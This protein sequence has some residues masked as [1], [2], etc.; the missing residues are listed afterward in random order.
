MQ[1]K[2]LYE[3]AKNEGSLN[4]LTPSF[5]EWRDAGDM[6]IGEFVDKNEVTSSLGSGTYNQ[7]LF[8]TDEGLVKFSLGGPA[9]KEI[10]PSLVVGNIYAI[11]YKGQVRISGGRKVNKFKASEIVTDQ[12][13]HNNGQMDQAPF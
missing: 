11:E 3:K 4:D 8:R 12:E 7:Y 5:F 6:V 9:D 1:Y 2:D 13:T 10:A